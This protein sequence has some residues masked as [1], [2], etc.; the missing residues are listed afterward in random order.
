MRVTLDI[1]TWLSQCVEIGGIDLFN[2][3]KSHNKFLRNWASLVAI[4][5][6]IISYSMIDRE[7]IICLADFHDIVPLRKVKA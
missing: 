3:D 1:T 4:S 5:K 6:T 2:N 7:I